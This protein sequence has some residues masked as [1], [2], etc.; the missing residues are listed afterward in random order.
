MAEHINNNATLLASGGHTWLWG[1]PKVTGKSVGTVAVVGEYAAVISIGALPVRITG[2]HGGKPALLTASGASRAA[3]DAAMT[4]IENTIELLIM[5]GTQVKWEDDQGHSGSAL[6]LRKYTRM[7][8]RQYSDGGQTVWQYYTID[9][10]ELNGG[11]T[12]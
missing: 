5:R 4:A 10:A 1:Q 6:Q 2:A 3:T 12:V 7:G 8:A 11:F 9:A